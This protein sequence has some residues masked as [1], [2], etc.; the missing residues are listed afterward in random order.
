[1]FTFGFGAAAGLAGAEGF[2]TEVAGGADPAGRDEEAGGPVTGALT[3]TFMG[4]LADGI[5]GIFP[6]RIGA[7]IGILLRGIDS[8]TGT[9]IGGAA[10]G[11]WTADGCAASELDMSLLLLTSRRTCGM[12]QLLEKSKKLV[13][14]DFVGVFLGSVRRVAVSS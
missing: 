8:F 1:M 9:F 3:N 11:G 4:P 2:G 12:R 10:T 13:Q 5:I 14:L 7:F 6:A